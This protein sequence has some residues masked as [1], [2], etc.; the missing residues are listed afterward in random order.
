MRRVSPR[1]IPLRTTPPL[2]NQKNNKHTIE[3]H[4]TNVDLLRFLKFG[5]MGVSIVVSS[6]DTGTISSGACHAS[7]FGTFSVQSPSNCPY[8]TS[9]GATQLLADGT[10]IAITGQDWASGGG[11]SR[12]YA[13]P[14]YQQDAVAAYFADYNP[15][16]LTGLFNASGRGIPDLSAVGLDIATAVDGELT[17]ELGTS[18]SAPLFAAMLNLVN[19]ERLAL[20]KST[21]G[22]VNPVL[23]ANASVI[24][25]DVQAGN[26]DMCDGVVKGFDAVPGWDPA[27]GLGTPQWQ[28]LKD[29]FLALP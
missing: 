4:T 25:K 3:K 26:N 1:A 14:S 9:V 23:Y 28:G 27:S 15:I 22:F 19:E 20:G 5:L 24:F 17:T 29:V 10:E 7:D 6:G 16:N 11:F 21:V 8:V 13:A 18:A 12:F 2:P